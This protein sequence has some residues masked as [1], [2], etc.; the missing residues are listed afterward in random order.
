MKH[1]RI[2]LGL[3][4]RL[5]KNSAIEW[6][7]DNAMR[8]SAALSYYSVFS[9]APLLLIAIGLVGLVARS[10]MLGFG[11]DQVQTVI[12]QQVSKMAGQQVG[13][14]VLAMVQSASKTGGSATVVGVLVLFFGASTVFGQLKDALNTIWGVRMKASVGIWGM[15]RERLL[16]FG[17]VL[18]IGFLLL[19]SLALG[20]VVAA[21][22]G[23]IVSALHLPT[24]V[25]GFFAFLLPFAVETLLFALLFQVLPDAKI[26]WRCVWLGAGVTALLF[27]LGK[28]VLSWYLGQASTTSS[29]GAA[30]SLVV[31]L[32]WVFYAS[33]ILFFGAEFTKVYAAEAKMW[34]E[35][36]E[37]AELAPKLDGLVAGA[38]VK[39]GVDPNPLYPNDPVPSLPM[40]ESLAPILATT[41]I[42]PRVL[43]TRP[44]PPRVVRIPHRAG[45]LEVVREHPGAQIGAAVGVGLLIGAVSR[46]LDRRA[47]TLSAGEHF[48]EG[49][50]KTVAAGRSLLAVGVAWAA[51]HLTKKA[52]RGYA[53]QG[54]HW[55][56]A[57]AAKLEKAM[58]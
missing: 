40:K 8:L 21:M 46:V 52:L 17:M 23:W 32:L 25:G 33:C 49:S 36:G 11:P 31:L 16:S 15:V 55:S 54:A 51:R 3:I 18:V 53:E 2:D 13:E 1:L 42:E 29:F 27:E 26:R 5:L 56:H 43:R 22:G 14:S 58:S 10:G 12:L 9:I 6:N 37:L 44:L 48:A 7:R 50:R 38:P 57:V 19:V 35:P 41:M 34:I 28:A 45:W 47:P 30:G 39:V 24:V 20:V 4:F